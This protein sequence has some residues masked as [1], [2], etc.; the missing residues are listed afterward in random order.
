MD[1]INGESTNSIN[2]KIYLLRLWLMI[3][4][5]KFCLHDQSAL[6]RLTNLLL[7]VVFILQAINVV[8]LD[9]VL[10]SNSCYN[11]LKRSIGSNPWKEKCNLWSLYEL[12]LLLWLQIVQVCWNIFQKFVSN[13]FMVVII[14]SFRLVY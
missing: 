2:Y 3:F 6:F 1:N 5:L 4:F 14:N 13:L 8:D 9:H 10:V 7:Q 11:W 12:Y